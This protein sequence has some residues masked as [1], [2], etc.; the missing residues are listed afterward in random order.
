MATTTSR[1][2]QGAAGGINNTLYVNNLNDKIKLDD[3]KPLLFELFASFGPI[4][5]VYAGK[6]QSRRGQAFIAFRE[7]S[8]AA[9]AMKTLNGFPFLDKPLR[10]AFARVKSDVVARAD[11]TFKPRRRGTKTAPAAPKSKR[12]VT[13]NVPKAAEGEEIE[14]VEMSDAED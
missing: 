6:S 14:E 13:V 3:L 8:N 7:A 10:V 2:K 4:L 9:L 11:G 5:A 12:R 1:P